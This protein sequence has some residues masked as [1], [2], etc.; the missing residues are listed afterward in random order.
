ME[1]EKILSGYCRALDKSRMV[2]A[3]YEDGKQVEVDC[4]YPGCPHFPSCSIAAQLN[5]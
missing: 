3:I 2:I 4:D 1:E 5:Q